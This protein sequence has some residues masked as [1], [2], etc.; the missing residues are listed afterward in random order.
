MSRV[1][2]VVATVV[3][4]MCLTAGSA[5]AQEEQPPPPE[6]NCYPLLSSLICEVPVAIGPFNFDIDVPVMFDSIFPSRP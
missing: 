6:V 4:A 5:A 3:L 1:L 2:A